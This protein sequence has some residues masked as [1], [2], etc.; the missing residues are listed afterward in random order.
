MTDVARKFRRRFPG[1]IVPSKPCVLKLFRKWR[2]FGSV[3]DKKKIRRSSDRKKLADIQARIQISPRKSSRRLHPE[4]W[5]SFSTY[6]LIKG[7]INVTVY[8]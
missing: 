3:Q 7:K 4:R 8:N 2:E 1:A 5:K 6:A